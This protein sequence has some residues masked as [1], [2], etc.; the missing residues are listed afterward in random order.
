MIHAASALPPA[1][2]CRGLSH[3]YGQR[4]VIRALDLEVAAGE[5]VCL[6]GPSG[7]GKSTTL[8]LA[9][10][11]EDPW[12]GTIAL[13]G[14]PVSGQ[15]RSVPPEERRIGFLFQDFALFP[16]LTVLGNVAFGL[17]ALPRP[18]RR[19][20]A[21]ACLAMVGMADYAEAYPHTLSGG[22]QQRVALARALAPEP[23]LMLL[24][25]PFS[26]LDSRLRRRIREET[27]RVLRARDVAA[28]MVTHDP[29]EALAMADRIALM[30]D[31]RIVQCAAPPLLYHQPAT[32]FAARFL[33]DVTEITARTGADGRIETPLGSVPA[34]AGL[35]AGTA[36]LVMVRPEA[37]L[38]H[39]AETAAAARGRVTAHRALGRL[40]EL[41]IAIDGMAEPVLVH[42]DGDGSWAIGDG[43]ALGLRSKGVFV[44]AQS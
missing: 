34:P 12:S 36:A 19:Q 35:D 8:R 2:A 5:I 39:P 11:L 30:E 41:R 27:A 18:A 31:G 6:L 40:T 43:V 4:A 38:L 25:E 22:Q 20:R 28:L 7:C 13:G 16:H 10:G 42:Q 44:F 1:L 15:G 26:G 17:R 37:V 14:R 21:G 29:E 23:L 9:A 24:D 33:G 3:G 32:P